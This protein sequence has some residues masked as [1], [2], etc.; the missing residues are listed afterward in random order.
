M[1]FRPEFFPQLEHIKF[2]IIEN[3]TTNYNTILGKLVEFPA[4]RS[5]SLG[6][7]TRKKKLICR[8]EYLNFVRRLYEK[9][10]LEVSRELFPLPS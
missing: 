1:R 2:D 7:Y 9:G 10:R 3:P 4:L 8:A 5:I 6:V